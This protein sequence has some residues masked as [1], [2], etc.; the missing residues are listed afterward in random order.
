MT[1]NA[2]ILS[3]EKMH[4]V[5]INP[6]KAYLEIL[7][8]IQTW[9]NSLQFVVVQAD[10]SDVGNAGKASILHVLDLVEL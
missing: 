9:R 4:R 7:K 6:Q 2:V 5:K 1:F 10:F 8:W 3:W